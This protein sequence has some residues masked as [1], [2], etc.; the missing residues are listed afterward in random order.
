[1]FQRPFIKRWSGETWKSWKSG[2]DLIWTK[3][4]LKVDIFFRHLESDSWFASF[5]S[6]GPC[7]AQNLMNWSWAQALHRWVYSVSCPFLSCVDL[8]F[9]RTSIQH[10]EICIKTLLSM[11]ICLFTTICKYNRFMYLCCLF[12]QVIQFYLTYLTIS[13]QRSSI[14]TTPKWVSSG[15]VWKSPRPMTP[16]ASVRQGGGLFD[17]TSHPNKPVTKKG[18]ICYIHQVYV[19]FLFKLVLY[20]MLQWNMYIYI[21]NVSMS[22]YCNFGFLIDLQYLD[23]WFLCRFVGIQSMNQRFTICTSPEGEVKTSPPGMPG[24]KEWPR[25]SCCC[26]ATDSVSKTGTKGGCGW[27][28]YPKLQKCV[29][30]QTTNNNNNFKVAFVKNG[31]ILGPDDERTMEPRDDTRKRPRI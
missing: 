20:L 16:K 15:E 7:R 8:M 17:V 5:K 18:V 1:M 3:Q 13:N 4:Y 22:L 10:R 26:E 29:W 24:W 30:T 19:I 28:S 6:S 12:A 27:F 11:R 25:Q 23:T 21:S 9:A 31:V 14:S 2:F